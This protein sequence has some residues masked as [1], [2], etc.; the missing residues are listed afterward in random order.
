MSLLQKT[1]V[2]GL[3][4]SAAALTRRQV[5][6]I[7][8]AGPPPAGPPPPP[9]DPAD[10]ATSGNYLISNCLYGKDGDEATGLQ[11]TL[12]GTAEVIVGDLGTDIKEGFRSDWFRHLFKDATVT[13]V[14]QWVFEQMYIGGNIT[15]GE[16]SSQ[17]NLICVRDG[18]TNTKMQEYW[19]Y[20]NDPQKS[21]VAS[22]LPD[23]A[24]IILCPRFFN[25]TAEVRPS[26]PAA[27][28]LGTAANTRAATL[29]HELVHMYGD[30]PDG[31]AKIG[32]E[33][34]G[35]Y[36]GT[37]VYD[38]CGLWTNRFKEPLRN[39][40]V[41]SSSMCCLTCRLMKWLLDLCILLCFYSREMFL[42]CEQF[43]LWSLMRQDFSPPLDG[44]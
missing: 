20:C 31:I 23:E 36:A 15:F 34:L 14:V 6:A 35:G 10:I 26:C 41:S 37:E 1:L 33:T 3:L 32:D 7:D 30:T 42:Q 16:V 8:A 27:K 21:V 19:E 5:S 43:S 4:G 28:Q 25:D 13:G 2:F 18:S 39:P 40:S 22:K 24:S 12:A 9:D 29:V 17:P 38:L 11:S 44:I